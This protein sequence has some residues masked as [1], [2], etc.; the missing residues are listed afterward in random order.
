V[1]GVELEH[2]GYG[3]TADI[4]PVTS[5]AVCGLTSCDGCT[6]RQTSASHSDSL[7]PWATE[8]PSLRALFDTALLTTTRTP[9]VFAKLRGSAPLRALTFAL[10]TELAALGSFVLVGA[11]LLLLLAPRFATTL[12][13]FSG[14]W[15]LSAGLWVLTAFLVVAL[16][17]L[18][19]ALLERGI[20]QRGGTRE[21]RLALAFACYSCGWDLLTS[22]IGLR[23]SLQHAAATGAPRARAMLAAVRAPRPAL[24]AYLEECRGLGEAAAAKVTRQAARD[25]VLFIML[26]LILGI[27]IGLGLVAASLT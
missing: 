4:P 19:A 22:P 27:G 25:A 2:D 18:W 8:G 20:T 16:H 10:A 24:R 12:M 6:P 9:T 14:A 7:L 21:P 11:L 13:R 26:M 1:E 17:L 15:A 23:L 5:C 3:G